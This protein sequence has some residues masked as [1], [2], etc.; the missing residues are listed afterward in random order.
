MKTAI[1]LIAFLMT[2]VAY[3]QIKQPA[4]RKKRVSW[5]DIPCNCDSLLKACKEDP[6]LGLTLMSDSSYFFYKINV[7]CFNKLCKFYIN[8]SNIYHLYYFDNWEGQPM[9]LNLSL[10]KSFYKLDLLLW[11]RYFHCPDKNKIA[12]RKYDSFDVM[13]RH[14]MEGARL[15]KDTAFDFDSTILWQE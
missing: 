2:V 11:M 8:S 14:T 15:V 7:Y 3:G 5:E 12:Q 4:V 13:E 6:C 9:Y 10:G 1:L